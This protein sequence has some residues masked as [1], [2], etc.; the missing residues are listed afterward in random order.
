[1]NMNQSSDGTCAA[2][3]AIA[4]MRGRSAARP[5]VTTSPSAA[6]RN[7]LAPSSPP[8]SHRPHGQGAL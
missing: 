1:M 3:A 5:S 7:D 8:A 6:N 4:L 2:I